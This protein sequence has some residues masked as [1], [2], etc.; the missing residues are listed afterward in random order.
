METFLLAFGLVL[1]SV[2]GLALGSDLR[3][4]AAQGIVRRPSLRDRAV[5]QRLPQGSGT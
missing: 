2:L 3:T 4:L 1:L 5:V